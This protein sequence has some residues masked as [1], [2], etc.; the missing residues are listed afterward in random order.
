MAKGADPLMP[1]HFRGGP[2]AR[3]RARRML[4]LLTAASVSVLTALTVLPA[5]QAG[6]AASPGAASPVHR[7][8]LLSQPQALSLSRREHKPVLVTGATTDSSTLTAEPDGKLSL[9]QWSAP[10]Q[11][12]VGGTWRPL[13]ATLRRSADGTVSPAVSTG[14]LVLSGGGTSQLAAMTSG[15]YTATFSLP[16]RTLPVP[17]LSGDTATYPSLL[18]GVDLKVTADKWGEFTDVLVVHNAAAATDPALRAFKVSVSSPH[19]TAHHDGDG[20]IVFR[21]GSGNVIFTEPTPTMWDSRAANVTGVRTAISPL[22][23]LRTDMRNGNPVVSSIAGPGEAARTARVT[24]TLTRGTITYSPAISLLTAKTTV[25]PVYVDPAAGGVLGYWVDVNSLYSTQP[26]LKPDPMQVG[27]CTSGAPVDCTDTNGNPINFVARAFVRMSEAPILYGATIYSSTL[28]LQDAWSPACDSGQGD[29]GVQVWVTQPISDSTDWDNQPTWDTEQDEKAFA[30]G[31]SSSCP[32]ATVGFNV[33]AGAKDADADRWPNLTFGIR[34]DNENDGYGW[35]Q[36][37]STVDMTTIYD[38]APSTPDDPTTSPATS[39]GSDDTVGLGDML[40]YADVKSPAT[41]DSLTAHFTISD[42]ST[43]ATIA[44]PTVTGL[45][46]KGG[47][48]PVR[49]LQDVFTAAAGDKVTEFTWSVYT[50]TT[51][52]YGTLDSGTLTC[53][54]SYNPTVPGAPDVAACETTTGTIG[55][56]LSFTVTPSASG[57]TPTDYEVQLNGGGPKDWPYKSGGTTISVTPTRWVNDM[58]V[59]AESAGGNVGNAFTCVFDATAPANAAD[60]DLTG[61]GIPDLIT[62]GGP[63]TGLPSGLW[64]AKGQAAADL[65]SGDGQVVPTGVDLGIEG[66]GIS[67]D[68]E[69]SDFDG[70]QVITGLFTGRGLQDYLVYYPPTNTNTD[71]SSYDGNAVILEGNGDGSVLESENSS[72]AQEF[73]GLATIDETTSGASTGYEPLQ[74]VNGYNSDGNNSGYPDLLSING[75]SGNYYL[76]YYENAGTDSWL[77]SVILTGTDSPDGTM[78]W[79]DWTLASMA[80]SAGN[81][82]LFL[83]NSS[84]GALWLWDDFTVNLTTN[85][86]AYTP[87]ELSTDWNPGTLSELRAANITGTSTSTI[88]GVWAVTTTG[89]VTSWSTSDLSTTPAITEDAS[90]TLIGPQHEWR[91]GDETSG[92]ATSAAD[93]GS[94]TA[95]PLTNTSGGDG[96]TWDDSDPV[97]RPDVDLD[98]TSTGYLTSSGQAVNTTSSYTISAWAD[99]TGTGGTV[100]SE[101]GSDASCIRLV[102][103]GVTTDGVTTYYWKFA[104]TT[105]N[106][107]TATD[108]ADLV[109][110]S[111]DYAILQGVWAHLTVTYDASTGYAELYVNGIP[112]TGGTIPSPWSS[113]CDTFALGQQRAGGGAIGVN[114]NGYVA[115]V[116]TWNTAMTPLQA[117]TLSGTSGYVLF[118]S[119]SHQYGSAASSTT[120]QWT[121]NDAEM[122]FYQGV[123]TV[124]ETGTGTAKEQYGT[125]GNTGAVFTLQNDGNLVI[126]KTAADAT[127]TTGSIWAS[128]TAGDTSDLMF[129]QPDGNLVIYEAD[130]YPVW[131]SGTEN[132]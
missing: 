93:T 114:F 55:T 57:A 124:Q 40:F 104:T 82:D 18:P 130:G 121:T 73:D 80:D 99:P 131:A 123:L 43:G 13:D 78:D 113:G 116:Q 62:P 76:E 109:A 47:V 111:K 71:T 6:A 30:D 31:Y 26:N 67:G 85:T 58:T 122:N 5:S 37:T 79:N 54:F 90:Q 110:S 106:S 63:G 45:S 119:D 101:Y 1:V 60:G 126:Y 72:N 132:G 70:S 128:N 17:V 98:G 21:T 68:Y 91:L 84:T 9:T 53:H 94:A 15:G 33:L 64:L 19:L 50:S 23:G 4:A 61:D 95:L 66:N 38:Y 27:D 65:T 48:A 102:S 112:A 3:P 129:L 49:V 39:C 89:T 28:Y 103:D 108:S 46:G 32:E 81:T 117:A 10:V 16:G 59:T 51:N 7:V 97:I 22:T 69:P 77:S 44:S 12:D 83:Y 41:G 35:K 87:Y 2:H 36:F 8:T 42:T 127:A 34:A 24:D 52:S 92:D 11:K 120:W 107:T 29:F 86:A 14:T 56:A 74:V 118:P 75:T 105:G 100:Y 25:W 125:S 96:A 20:S 115:D 88:P